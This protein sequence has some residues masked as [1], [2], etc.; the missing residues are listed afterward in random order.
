VTDVVPEELALLREIAR[1]TREAAVPLARERVERLVDSD[2]KLRVYAAMADGT[3]SLMALERSTGVNH[4]DIRR[5]VDTWEAQG[6]AES[7]AKPPRA[8]FTIAEL[9]ITP[10]PVRP[11]RAPKGG[12]R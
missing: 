11:G 3:E 5:W 12:A 10:P 4:N 9:G 2:G 6:I 8:T 7:G 1:W